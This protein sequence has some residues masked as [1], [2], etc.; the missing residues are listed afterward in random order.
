MIEDDLAS[1]GDELALHEPDTGP[2]HVDGLPRIEV[3]AS[4]KSAASVTDQMLLAVRAR[5]ASQDEAEGYVRDYADGVSG[6]R[7]HGPDATTDKQHALEA[8]RAHDAALRAARLSWRHK[9]ELAC[10]ELYV[11]SNPKKL[12]SRI[13]EAA[14]VAV[15]W[16][17]GL[18]VRKSSERIAAEQGALRRVIARDGS[19]KFVPLRN[20]WWK[21]ALR[22]LRLVK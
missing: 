2:L 1:E 10:A 19:V 17:E 4:I 21:R 13:I 11:E 16:G 7:F 5:R 6:T 8:Q 18:E 15:S 20:P 22:F 9:L 3:V 14:A 12:R